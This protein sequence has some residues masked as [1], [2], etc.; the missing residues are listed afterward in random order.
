M[1]NFLIFGVI[2]ALLAGCSSKGSP[3]TKRQSSQIAMPEA[4]GP[5]N[6]A[7]LSSDRAARSRKLC[8]C[9]QAVANQT[10][11][12]SQQTRA[13]TFYRSPHEAQVVRQSDRATDERFWEAYRAYGERSEKIC[14]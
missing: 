9:I 7:C 6:S 12:S 8:G 11:N 14:T 3:Q 4:S 5:I 13:A 10:L 1:N 2:A